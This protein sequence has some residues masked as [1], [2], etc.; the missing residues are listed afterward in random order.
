MRI[1]VL[2]D[3]HGNVSRLDAAVMAQKQARHVFFLGDC[4]SDIERVAA[5]RSDRIF[6]IVKG[7]CDFLSDMPELSFITLENTKIMF[8]HG[9][10]LSVKYSTDRLFCRAKTAGAQIA[11]YGHTH[12]AGSEYRD[13]IYAVNPGSVAESRSG[14]DSYAVIDITP[15]GIMPVIIK[16]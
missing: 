3:S 9:H 13:G 12:I 16:I 8:A 4:V 7:N 15:N 1:I 10:T 5:F 11:L 14:P 2:S 6:H